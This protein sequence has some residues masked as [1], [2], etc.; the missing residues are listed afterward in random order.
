MNQ[1]KI[2]PCLWFHTEGGSIL[3]VINYYKNIFATNFQESAIIPLGV[4][5]SGNTEMCEVSIFGQKYNLMS[6]ANEHNKFNDALA[7][8]IN[9]EDQNEIDKYWIYFTKEGNEVQCGWCTDKFGLRW[10][11]LPKN[12]G[13][14]MSKPNSFEVM[15]N[16]KKIIIKEYLNQ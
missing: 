1:N 16:Q 4:T 12:L 7:F 14:L 13:E 9:C 11:V 3:Q 2:V 6:T 10:Q 5:P 15:M 8:A